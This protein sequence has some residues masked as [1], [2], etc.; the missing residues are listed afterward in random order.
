MR[1]A[2]LSSSQVH[3]HRQH[4]NLQLLLASRYTTTQGMGKLSRNHHT[5]GQS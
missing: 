2:V 1:Y 4:W 3:V 5:G